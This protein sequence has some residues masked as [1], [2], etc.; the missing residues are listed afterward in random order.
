MKKRAPEELVQSADKR[1]R[2]STGFYSHLD[3]NQARLP[4]P[5]HPQR[6]DH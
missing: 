4:I 2:T 6:V 1:T 5:P 3:L